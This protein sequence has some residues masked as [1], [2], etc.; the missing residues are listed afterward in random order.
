VAGL[1]KIEGACRHKNRNVL[2]INGLKIMIRQTL[3]RLLVKKGIMM[4]K[5]SATA[6]MGKCSLKLT[7]GRIPITA[8]SKSHGTSREKCG[9]SY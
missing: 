6:D 5:D 4:T 2:I 8:T 3:D 9:S 7:T 1:S